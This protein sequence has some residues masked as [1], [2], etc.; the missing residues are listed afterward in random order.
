MQITCVRSCDDAYPERLR[1]LGMAPA[2]LFLRGALCPTRPSVAIVGSR[3]ASAAA[4]TAA[5]S[6]AEGLAAAGACVVSGGA[7]GVDAAA[8]EGALQA[9]LPT[10]AVL[11]TGVDVAYPRC[12]EAL[13]DQIVAAGGCLLSIFPLGTPPKPWHFPARNQIIAALAD[14]VVVVEAGADSGSRYTAAAAQRLGRPVGAL[15]GS[16]GT[17][18][19][20]RGEAGLIEGP[21]DVLALLRDPAAL[22]RPARPPAPE[23]GSSRQL[24]L[25]LDG[26]PR[27]LSDLSRKSGLSAAACA[28]AIMDLELSGFCRRLAGG[29][30]VAL[31]QVGP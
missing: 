24:L 14:V 30:Y 28:A 13:F 3:A 21:A 15:A 26:V 9:G 12:H 7:L 31:Q 11:G 18:E 29:R 2:Q 25:A 6:L 8:H 16:P 19:I 5:F 20:L 17:D 4:R 23:Q 1:A 27:D 22:R 10:C